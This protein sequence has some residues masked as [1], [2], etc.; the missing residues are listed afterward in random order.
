M[1]SGFLWLAGTLVM[2]L[3]YNCSGFISLFN[4]G[5]AQLAAKGEARPCYC[6]GD[7]K[8]WKWGLFL[9]LPIWEAAYLKTRL[10]KL[11]KT[12]KS[13]NYDSLR[14]AKFIV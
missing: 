6:P 3:I 8:C 1:S 4:Q 2:S 5:A 9:I 12:K 14:C 13:N 10:K 7:Q 11:Q